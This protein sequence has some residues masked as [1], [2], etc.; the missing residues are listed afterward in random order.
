MEQAASTILVGCQQLINDGKLSLTKKILENLV[1]S[2]G[3][4]TPSIKRDFERVDYLLYKERDFEK[5]AELLT[6]LSRRVEGML[7]EET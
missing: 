6:A 1:N 3:L 4:A 2:F 7:G 5:A